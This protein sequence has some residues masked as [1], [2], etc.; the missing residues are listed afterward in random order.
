M[1]AGRMSA[2]EAGAAI[3]SAVVAARMVLRMGALA[4]CLPVNLLLIWLMN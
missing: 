4:A 1:G 3:R 2:A